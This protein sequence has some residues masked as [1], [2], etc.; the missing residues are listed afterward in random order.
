LRR[1]T[2]S[3]KHL[4]FALREP[5]RHL[6]KPSATPDIPGIRSAQDFGAWLSRSLAARKIFAQLWPA[7]LNHVRLPCRAL[8]VAQ[9]LMGGAVGAEGT[10]VPSIGTRKGERFTLA[11]PFFGSP[12]TLR[13][14]RYRLSEEADELPPQTG[15]AFRRKP[16]CR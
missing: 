6:E 2:S 16:I 12:G 13:A 7:Q 14:N 9:T 1:Q 3:C 8:D 15:N 11:E 10:F 4:Y 5:A